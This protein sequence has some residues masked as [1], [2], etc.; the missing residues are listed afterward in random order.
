MY[1]FG[2]PPDIKFGIYDD[3]IL[4]KSFLLCPIQYIA[5]IKPIVI[6]I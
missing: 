2:M 5:T 3:E 4:R 6:G 1:Y